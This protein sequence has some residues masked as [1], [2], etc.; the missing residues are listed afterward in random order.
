[1][2][3][4]STKQS[5]SA[6]FIFIFCFE[7]SFFLQ[8]YHRKLD[9]FTVIF[10]LSKKVI[11]VF[12]IIINFHKLYFLDFEVMAQFSE[13]QKGFRKLIYNGFGYVKKREKVGKITWNCESASKLRC[14]AYAKT[15]VYAI[16]GDEV[17]EFGSHTH[18]G[19]ANKFEI[20]ATRSAIKRK[21]MDS[22]F[23]PKDV[24]SDVLGNTSASVAAYL[25]R[26]ESLARNIHRYRKA[27][28]APPTRKAKTAKGKDFW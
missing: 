5:D 18:E 26:V 7:N 28:S 12:L 6:I 20:L 21:A 8:P 3:A 4:T 23:S 24:V 14:R 25:P 16:D 1:M 27:T 19:V 13:T 10:T 22:E 2:S 15:A 17:E 11:L 9:V